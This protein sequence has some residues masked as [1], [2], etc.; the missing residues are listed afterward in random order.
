MMRAMDEVFRIIDDRDRLNAIRDY[1]LRT[2][3]QFIIETIREGRTIPRYMA[4]LI[5]VLTK[6][7]DAGYANAYE[8]L[9]KLK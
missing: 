6:L 2:D 8:D 1:L 7:Y 4:D 3:P 5:I 9:E